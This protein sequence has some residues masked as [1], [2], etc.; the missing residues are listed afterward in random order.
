LRDGPR[1]ERRVLASIVFCDLVGSTAL[2]ERLDPE[3]LRGVQARYFAVAAGALQE[4]GGLVEKY[5]GDAVMCVFGLPATHEDDALRAVRGALDVAHGVAR[6][7]L[8]LRAELGIGLAVRIGVNTGEVMAGD[9]ASGQ[10]L[11]TG[12]A[13]NTAARLEQAAPRGGILIGA[14]THRLVARHVIAEPATP[15]SAK[16][17]SEPL[18]AWRVHGLATTRAAPNGDSRLV[19]RSAEL[20]Q[21]RRALDRATRDRSVQLVILSGEAGIG[22]SR[23]VAEFAS[24]LTQRVLVGACPSY[25]RGNTYRPLREVLESVAPFATQA[26]VVELLAGLPEAPVVA[27]RLLRLTGHAPGPVSSEEAFGAVARFFAALAAEAPLVVAVEDLQWAEPTFLDLLQFLRE[28]LA[29]PV[30]VVGTARE[31]FFE[32]RPD[33]AADALRLKSL[34]PA[35]AADLVGQRHA[36]SAQD[37]ARVVAL[38]EGN[39]LFLEQLGAAFAEGVETVPPDIAG[40]LAARLDRLD[41]P[42]RGVLEAA[43]IVGREFWPGALTSLLDEAQGVAELSRTLEQLTTTE[44]VGGG[45]SGALAGPTGLSGIF[46]GGRMHFRHALVHDAVLSALPKMRRAALH[47]RFASTL[48]SYPDHEPAVVGYHLEQA[49]RLRMELRPRDASPVVAGAAAAELEQAGRQA[50]EREDTPAAGLLLSRAKALLPA[51]SPHA[52]RIDALF[53]RSA[54][55]ASA[56]DVGELRAGERLGGF[57]VEALTGRGGMA[58][59]YR[60][61]DPQRERTVAL[62]VIAPELAGDLS[63]RERFIRESRITASIHHPAVIPVYG[64]GEERGR[65]YIAMRYVAGGDLDARIRARGA[66]PPAEAIHFIQDLAGALDAAHARG[67]VHRGVKP[68]NALL[69]DAHADRVYLTDFGLA[70]SRQPAGGLTEI[71][72]R[73]ATAAYSAPEQVRGEA[74]DARADIYALGGLLYTLLTGSVPFPA[75]SEAEV[76]TAHLREP[77]PRPSRLVH[78]IP[79]ALDA[80]VARAMAKDP[81]QRYPSAGDLARAAA[82]AAR[83]ERPPAD[84]GSVA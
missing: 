42:A 55:A 26:D 41:A 32:E 57:V 22:K 51:A 14:L 74:V 47:E 84:Q 78:G 54:T 23:L 4:H 46:S 29:A 8:E 5:I 34:T 17:K 79:G 1:R 77:P 63:F 25:G 33:F 7:S 19:G 21:L 67:L 70:S 82:A 72:Q 28:S 58:A 61:R 2:G 53:E 13:V 11:V 83:G 75:S 44:F 62:K 73:I 64:A 66:L 39:P 36:L 24:G 76:L 37:A 38:A 80:V 43:A 71:G 69:E 45:A 18:A 56:A 20:E 16:G 81:G 40:L 31:D 3:V 9:H 27:Q 52:V 49:A 60:A 59:V 65:L 48:S 10:T 35:A 68:A 50:L 12:D 6:L 30:L 15:I